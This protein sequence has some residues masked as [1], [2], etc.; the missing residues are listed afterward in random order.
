MKELM[1]MEDRPTAVFMSNYETALGGVMAI[2]DSDLSCP[3]DVSL[4]GFDDLLVSS[5]VRPS[6]WTV[7]QPIEM[8]C[9]NAVKLLLSRI[10]NEESE[11]PVKMSFGAKI[12]VGKSVRNL[13]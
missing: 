3:E 7:E 4:F 6:L 13:G 9:G 10:E 1:A 5:I 12:R 8:L 11:E 2:N